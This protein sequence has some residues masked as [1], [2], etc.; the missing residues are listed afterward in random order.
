MSVQRVIWCD[1]EGCDHHG[2]SQAP[3]WITVAFGENTP[4]RH[5]CDGDC[6]FKW[7][8]ANSEPPTTIYMDGTVDDPTDE[9]RDGG[10]AEPDGSER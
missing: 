3:G 2:S 9:R 5:F 10:E 8:G 4:R 1:R 6:L 7:A